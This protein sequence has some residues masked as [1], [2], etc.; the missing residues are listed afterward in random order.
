MPQ[1]GDILKFEGWRKTQRLPFV[2]YADF[3]AL[4]L[5]IEQQHG[6]N[7][8]TFQQHRAMSYGFIVKVGDHVPA[9]LLEQFEIPRSVVV[10][11][12]SENA[13]DVAK[14]FVMAVTSIAERI[15][16]LLSKT[17]V[18][19][20][21][22]DEQLRV[23]HTKIHCELCK[24]KFSHGNRLVAHHDHLTGEFLKS[25]CNNCNLKLVTQNF[26]PCFIHNLSRYD[27]HFIVTELGYN[28]QR[29]SVIANSEENYI[30]FSK[31]IDNN[32]SIRFVDSCRFMASKLSTLAENLITDDFA[33]FG[34][35]SKVFCSDDMPL[36]T[37]KGVYPYEY[38]NSWQRLSETRLPEKKHFYST[39]LEAH[40]E[41][42][43]YEHAT[44]VW[45][46]FNCQTLGDY[47]DLYL[48]IDVLLLA[49]VFENFRDLCISTYNLDPSNYQ[50]SPALTFDSMLKYT[51]IELELVSDYDKLLMLETGIRGGLVQASR[52][53]ARSNNEKTPG[54]DCNQPKSYLVY[55][56]CKYDFF[57]FF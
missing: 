50:T 21:I 53:F 43:E 7:T 54:F 47:S 52:R 56:D 36:V 3:E 51:R 17:N 1:E 23:H 41:H 42:E 22:T 57:F 10:Y 16:E 11:R 9:E 30:S 29:I 28:E 14:Q 33:K 25:L 13:D 12:G 35:I 38:T 46:H 24:I 40:I 49:D 39:L 31:Y 34:E 6:S 20:V 48:K 5:P 37:R 15:H 18:P 2:I 19:I 4:L 26:V 45:T 55:Q 32:F 27:A 8:R 44:Q